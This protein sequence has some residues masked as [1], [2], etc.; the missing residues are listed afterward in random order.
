MNILSI[1]VKNMEGKLFWKGFDDIDC[2]ESCGQFIHRT[3]QELDLMTIAGILQLSAILP[4]G[5]FLRDKSGA[6]KT[7]RSSCYA[8]AVLGGGCAYIK[9]G[10]S[11]G[12]FVSEPR[13]TFDTSSREQVEYSQKWNRK[14]LQR[15]W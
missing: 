12:T 2:G 5:F 15:K 13:I 1:S 10:S 14:P 11:A 6:L 4:F 8:V 3:Q 7:T 9:T